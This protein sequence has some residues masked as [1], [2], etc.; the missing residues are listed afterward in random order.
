MRSADPPIGTFLQAPSIASA[1]Q[2]N[3][4][5]F[6]R[7]LFVMVMVSFFSP[8]RS[9]LLAYCVP[10]RHGADLLPRQ[11]SPGTARLQLP[12]ASGI[13]GTLMRTSR[14]IQSGCWDAKEFQVGC[15]RVKLQQNLMF[16]WA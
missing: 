9:S 8:I 12:N 15:A 14:V 5:S 10:R 13:A 4:T 2:G 1:A 3:C 16:K 7:S 6:G 11:N